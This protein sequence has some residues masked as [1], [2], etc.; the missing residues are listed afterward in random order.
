MEA[1][2][3]FYNLP[4]ELLTKIAGCFVAEATSPRS[5]DLKTLRLSSPRFAYL[6]VIQKAV[7]LNIRFPTSVDHLA[8]LEQI[9]INRI[10]PFVKTISFKAQTHGSTQDKELLCSERL[11]A[12]WTR[13]LRALPVLEKAYL[14][15]YDS[16]ESQSQPQSKETNLE[17]STPAQMGDALI[18]AAVACLLSSGARIRKL[19]V[20]CEITGAQNWPSVPG[21]EGLDLS[22]LENVTYRPDPDCTANQVTT[23][24]AEAQ[25]AANLCAM[26][27]KC[28]GWIR[29]LK[30]YGDCV[31]LWPGEEI[32]NLP[33]LRYL[34]LEYCGVH[35]RNLGSWLPNMP[36]LQ[37]FEVEGTHDTE[38]DLTTWL[39]VFN[40]IRDHPRNKSGIRVVFHQAAPFNGALISLDYVTNQYEETLSWYEDVLRGQVEDDPWVDAHNYIM[41]YMV[42]EVGYNDSLRMWLEDDD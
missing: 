24:N 6:K 42:G 10:A 23:E 20:C 29:K 30:I 39:H 4:E 7:F 1:R 34:K 40:A 35:V 5:K 36:S 13:L 18:A 22:K 8:R 9:D 3:K 27:H 15:S 25:A 33:E 19:Q 17:T 11:R 26:F 14:W 16:P 28:H 2:G 41:L 38:R 21:W 32:V 37:H 31:L 12:A